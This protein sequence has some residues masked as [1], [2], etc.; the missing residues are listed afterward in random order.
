[1]VHVMLVEWYGI[2]TRRW[3]ARVTQSQTKSRLPTV[4]LCRKLSLLLCILGALLALAAA[5]PDGGET[6]PLPGPGL[7][8][9]GIPYGSVSGD[10][11][12]FF[13]SKAAPAGRSSNYN[14][15][16]APIEQWLR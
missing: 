2:Y 10:V 6:H 1:M 12:S 15:D 4:M 14:V 9:G 11:A 7:A 13:R 8:Y 5:R 16:F 3:G